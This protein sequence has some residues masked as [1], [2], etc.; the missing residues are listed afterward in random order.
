L[1]FDQG[2]SREE[3]ERIAYESCVSEWM[4][5][6]LPVPTDPNRGCA[7]CG[8]PA[9]Q[10]AVIVPFLAGTGAVW[11]HPECWPAWYAELKAEAAAALAE[12]AITP[13]V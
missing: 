10:S 6:N 7:R 5:G 9:T 8:E 13:P 1:E 12:M 11:L 3:A 2:R 4:N